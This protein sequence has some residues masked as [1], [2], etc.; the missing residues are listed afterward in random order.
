MVI[1]FI[2]S[3]LSFL[4]VILPFFFIIFGL[5]WV[6]FIYLNSEKQVKQNEKIIELLNEIKKQ[7][8][9]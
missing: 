3:M 6:R 9:S 7:N 4:A 5:R 2:S 8:M 1:S